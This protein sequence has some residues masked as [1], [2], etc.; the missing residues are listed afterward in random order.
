MEPARGPL[1]WGLSR[2]TD[3]LPV[4]GPI[5][6]AELDPVTQTARCYDDAGQVIELGKHGTNKETSTTSY[7]GGSDGSKPQSQSADDSTTDYAPD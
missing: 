7:S 4:P 6:R 5:G 2:L 3:R 1:P